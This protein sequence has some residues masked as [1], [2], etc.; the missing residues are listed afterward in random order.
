MRSCSMRLANMNKENRTA[1]EFE[2]PNV[3]ITRAQAKG[4]ATSRGLPPLRPPTK[5]DQK[6]IRQQN[7]KRSAPD[8]NKNS[9]SVTAAVQHKKRAVLKDIANI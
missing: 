5:Q 9:I 1:A 3:R 6:P 2:E 7:S 8:E 4:K